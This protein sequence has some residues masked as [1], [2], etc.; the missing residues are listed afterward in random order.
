MEGK[1]DEA[2]MKK[3]IMAVLPYVLANFILEALARAGYVSTYTE[4]RGGM[5]HQSKA[6]LFIVVEADEVNKVI[7]IIRHNLDPVIH[8]READKLANG[9][10]LIDPDKG[11]SAIFVWDVDQFQT[12]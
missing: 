8:K 1:R 12:L 4:S 2:H 7:D 5:M 10:T 3:M 11:G 9:L 6:S